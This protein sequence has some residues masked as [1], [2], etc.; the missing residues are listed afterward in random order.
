M[1][2]SLVP[3]K[4]P[5]IYPL[6][7]YFSSIITLIWTR[8]VAKNWGAICLEKNFSLKV[9]AV[10]G[11]DTSACPPQVMIMIKSLIIGTIIIIIWHSPFTIHYSLSTII[12]WHY[13]SFNLQVYMIQGLLYI[14]LSDS[15]QNAPKYP[16]KI[17]HLRLYFPALV[18]KE[19]KNI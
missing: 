4:L 15:P 13:Q 6:W 14:L 3:L 8:S 12:H 7:Q 9:Q 2:A 19:L 18:K 5:K 1:A 11:R 17:C 16:S 10:S